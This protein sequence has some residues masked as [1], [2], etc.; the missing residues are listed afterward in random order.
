[1]F[2]D[3]AGYLSSPKLS[4]LLQQAAGFRDPRIVTF[5]V[6]ALLRRGEEVPAEALETAAAAH[7][8]RAM[9]YHGLEALGAIHRFPEAW[10]TWKA[11][12]ATAMAEWLLYPTELGREPDELVLEHV[13]P[14][15]PE[16]TQVA[17]VWRFRVAEEPWQAGVS[18]IHTLTGTPGPLDGSHTFS[19]FETWESATPAEH[20][21]RC[22]GT[23][24][25]FLTSD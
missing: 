15:N 1:M 8:T 11:F 13:E 3:L 10:S 4:P 14:L 19:R 7:E 21:E 17:Y 25:E 9:L 20:L 6:L 12:G 18:G 23:V 2:L 16:G 5:A 22:L 24:E